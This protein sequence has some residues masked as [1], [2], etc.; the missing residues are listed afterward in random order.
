MIDF[1]GKG[2]IV[3]SAYFQLLW[4]NSPYLLNDPSYFYTYM[5]IKHVWGWVNK[6]NAREFVNVTISL[7]SLVFVLHFIVEILYCKL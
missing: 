3:N 7:T 5:D 2:A 1:F 4:K 6:K